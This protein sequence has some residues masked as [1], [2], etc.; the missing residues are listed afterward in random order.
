MSGGSF[1]LP[2]RVNFPK[3][4][5]TCLVVDHR[6]CQGLSIMHWL[7]W[8]A[9][10]GMSWEI[11]RRLWGKIVKRNPGIV[12][13]PLD[14]AVTKVWGYS[15]ENAR[16][17]REGRKLDLEEAQLIVGLAAVLAGYLVQKSWPSGAEP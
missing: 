17:G 9:W 14:D 3:L 7:L 13:R 5:E 15:S 6:I 8:N 11:R 4:S 2:L 1:L 12:P 10:P 16:H